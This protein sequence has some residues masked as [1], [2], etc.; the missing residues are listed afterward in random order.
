MRRCHR[1]VGATALAMLVACLFAPLVSTIGTALPAGNPYEWTSGTI[2]L[3]SSAAGGG[4][5]L[6]VGRSREYVDVPRDTNGWAG[7][8]GIDVSTAQPAAL[9]CTRDVIVTGGAARVLTYPARYAW[10]LA[11][12]A[13]GLC[14][15]MFV[16]LVRLAVL[17]QMEAAGPWLRRRR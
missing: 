14:A 7:I 5:E 12:V 9:V 17:Q 4:C 13:A 8:G 6:T 2:F 1:L 15:A 3:H 11:V 10:V 16:A